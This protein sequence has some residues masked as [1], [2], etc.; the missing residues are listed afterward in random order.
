M[1]EGSILNPKGLT[2]A[3]NNRRS[4]VWKIYTVNSEVVFNNGQIIG[5]VFSH[6]KYKRFVDATGNVGNK[7]RLWDFFD[8]LAAPFGA[9]GQKAIP[10]DY[11]D[12]ILDMAAGIKK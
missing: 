7:E 10:I 5:H 12:A 4:H 6:E 11:M 1:S 3:I 2:E 8:K 9:S